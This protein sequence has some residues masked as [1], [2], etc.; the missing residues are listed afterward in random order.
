MSAPRF[1]P[2]ASPAP[3]PP[4]PE[5]QPR[6]SYPRSAAGP[7][8]RARVGGGASE[9]RPSG[10]APPAPGPGHAA[11]WG[12][13]RAPSPAGCV[14]RRPAG[15][16]VPGPAHFREWSESLERHLTGAAEAAAGLRWGQA[17]RPGR[18]LPTSSRAGRRPPPARAPHTRL[19]IWSPRSPPP[20]GRG[21]GVQRLPGRPGPFPM[22][23]PSP[24]FRA[25]QATGD[26]G[27]SCTCLIRALVSFK[28][29][30]LLARDGKY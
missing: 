1:P 9:P 25:P 10:S 4:R 20:P 11:P 6:G 14:P 29:F 19:G 7:R 12:R 8:D 18:G 23:L 5:P 15:L 21:L 30:F 16:C 24:P 26:E 2:G 3:G 17:A 27:S 28:R 13:P 22:P